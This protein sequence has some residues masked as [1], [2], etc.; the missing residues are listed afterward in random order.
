MQT[1]KDKFC[2]NDGCKQIL[3]SGYQGKGLLNSMRKGALNC[4]LNAKYLKKGGC[5]YARYSV[6]EN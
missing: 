1:N 6:D 5:E 2:Y 4:P 3:L